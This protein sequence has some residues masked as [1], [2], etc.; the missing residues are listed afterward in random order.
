MTSKHKDSNA[1]CFCSKQLPIIFVMPG[2]A[3]VY[4]PAL[5][6][7]QIDE[8]Y[9]ENVNIYYFIGN[10]IEFNTIYIIILKSVL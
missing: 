5:T 1:H 7:A 10:N 3:E 8:S 9:S 4:C 6:T 2:P